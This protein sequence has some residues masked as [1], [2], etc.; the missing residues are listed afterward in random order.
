MQRLA[1]P[2]D[3]AGLTAVFYSLCYLGFGVPAAMAFVAGAAGLSY[4]TMF[5]VGACAAVVC[6]VAVAVGNRRTAAIS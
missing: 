2:D 5:V 3:L 6:L 4:P 1:G